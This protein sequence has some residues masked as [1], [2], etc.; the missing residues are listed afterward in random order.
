L[1]TAIE[2]RSCD[3][4]VVGGGNAGFCAALSASQNGASVIL[5][6]KCP[7]KWAGGNSFFTAGAFRTVHHGL[8]DLLPI[9]T[10]VDAR[11]ASL[12]DLNP[13]T[14][15]DFLGDMDRIRG[16]QYDREL[17][18]KLVRESRVTVKWLVREGLRFELSFNRQV[19]I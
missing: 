7:K 4:I 9:V 15:D 6:D 13:Y 2:F 10:N 14:E 1:E 5:I 16:G 19:S 11:K 18:G 12:I 3:V 17:E 8:E